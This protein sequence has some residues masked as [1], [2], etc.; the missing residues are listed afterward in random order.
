MSAT[1]SPAN[2]PS[3]ANVAEI[4]RQMT[5]QPYK[6]DVTRRAYYVDAMTGKRHGVLVRN[7]NLVPEGN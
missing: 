4:V 3:R 7:F 1:L 6:L 5:N 2:V